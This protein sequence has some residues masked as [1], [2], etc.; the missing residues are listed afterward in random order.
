MQD[1]EAIATI[2]GAGNSNEVLL[3]SYSDKRFES[4]LTY[5]RLTQFDF[6]G[7]SKEYPSQSISCER[8]KNAPFTVY[9]NPATDAVYIE[10]ASELNAEE[11]ESVELINI[12]GKSLSTYYLQVDK[13]N[14]R[15][16]IP[17]NNLPAGVYVLRVNIAG[18]KS[19]P[20][21]ILFK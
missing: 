15:M 20:V 17:R 9:P 2:D 14:M 1:W 6:N 11:I 8:K 5:Y 4:G 12:S 18:E 19:E 3:Y 10:F 16:V 13:M 21:K 7:N